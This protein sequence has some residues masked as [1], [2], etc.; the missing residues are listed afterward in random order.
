MS[1]WRGSAART[2]CSSSI[3][4][5]SGPS[6]LRFGQAWILMLLAVGGTAQAQLRPFGDAAAIVGA[7]IEIGDGRVIPKG[8]VL[9][10]DGLIEAVGA[11]VRVPPD[12]EVVP[13]DG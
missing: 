8:T 11:G 12:A 3:S 9:V 13:G 7:R 10:R 2:C 4:P 1:A 5:M 6:S